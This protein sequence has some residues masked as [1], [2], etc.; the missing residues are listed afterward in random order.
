[1]DG[2][3]H[4]GMLN[5][6]IHRQLYRLAASQHLQMLKQQ[7]MIHGAWVVIV[8]FYALFHRQMTL[9]LV[10]AVFRN[11]ADMFIADLFT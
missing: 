10:I 3:R 4:T 5:V 1:M 8:G 6:A 9:I 11:N 2:F 7:T